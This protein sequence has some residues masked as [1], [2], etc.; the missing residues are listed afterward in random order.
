MKPQSDKPFESLPRSQEQ[1]MGPP[2]SDQFEGRAAARNKPWTWS[3]L[4][5]TV[6]SVLTAGAI[7]WVRF[8]TDKE[9]EA[10]PT[11]TNEP[12]DLKRGG[13]FG[14]P[15]AQAQVLC[16]QKDL[17]VS[18]WNNSEHLYVQAIL[19]EDD[20][21]TPGQTAD[22]R[23]IGDFSVLCLD[24][25]AD[26]QA[27][28]WVDRNYMLNPWPSLPGL[29]YAVV[30]G[31]K[32]TTKMEA[33]SQGRGAIRYLAGGEGK[34]VRVDSYLIPL[35]EIR[36]RPGEKVRL[37]YWASSPRPVLTLNSVGFQREGSYYSHS[38]PLD[39]YHSITLSRR[40]AS[41]DLKQVPEGRED[42]VP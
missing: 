28:P 39:S 13:A 2:A 20:D 16:D 12:G 25:D 32:V 38:L 10:V 27:S 8:Q 23:T 36:K 18:F 9:F 33:D 1:L 40:Q 41:L 19:W 4:A 34:P 29:R 17:R 3:L 26:Q 14:F 11:S 37:A 35:S 6:L 24:V 5:G 15:Q 31:N 21:S 30:I 42:I 7:V 22:G